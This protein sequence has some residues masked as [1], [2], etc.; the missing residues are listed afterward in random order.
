MKTWRIALPMYGFTPRLRSDYNTLLTGFSYWLR[1]LG[2]D[3]PVAIDTAPADLYEHWLAP[4]LLLSQTCGYPLMTSLRGRVTLLCTPAYNAEGC[5]DFRYASRLI[6]RAE[7]M[8]NS[9]V[10]L[11]G[12]TA[13]M[14]GRDSNSGM[15]VLRH[16]VAQVAHDGHFFRQVA[17][18]GS[19][20]GSMACV[21]DGSADVAAVDCV[22]WAYAKDGVPEL[23]A[24]LRTLQLSVSTPGLPLI[25]SVTLTP[26]Q[27]ALVRVALDRLALS[28]AELFTRLRLLGFRRTQWRDYEVIPALETEAARL[29][30]PVV[31]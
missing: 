9:L 1:K 24:G 6:V 21:V 10:D 2:W 23:C 11:R 12:R 17:L 4:D 18:S 5:N 25:G 28:D 14:N 3:E 20:L 16:A 29:G 8:A 22:T 19:H 26:D 27:Q 7:D 15:N 30:Y 13:V 31:Q